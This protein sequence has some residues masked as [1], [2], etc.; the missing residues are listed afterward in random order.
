MMVVSVASAEVV[1]RKVCSV[2]CARRADRDTA[3]SYA[4]SFKPDQS[5]ER[6]FFVPHELAPDNGYTQAQLDTI[7]QT[8]AYFG[9][10]LLPL[11]PHLH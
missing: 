1:L 3:H 8:L 5:R 11:D 6:L 10:D 4:F 2:G 7:E 9:F